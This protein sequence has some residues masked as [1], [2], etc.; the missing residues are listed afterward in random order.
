MIWIALLLI[1]AGLAYYFFDMLILFVFYIQHK[2]KGSYT[3]VRYISLETLKSMTKSTVVV[4]DLSF[5]FNLVYRPLI[6]RDEDNH[7]I[8]FLD[9]REMIYA[10]PYETT[11][12]ICKSFCEYRKIIKYLENFS[13][14]HIK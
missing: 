7:G 1:F 6:L 5:C 8:Y 14:E 12:L 13:M 4:H 2:N 3:D 10:M 9:Y 11:V